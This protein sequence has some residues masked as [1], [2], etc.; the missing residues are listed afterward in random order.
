MDGH[1]FRGARIHRDMMLVSSVCRRALGCEWGRIGSG[2]SNLT[3]YANLAVTHLPGRWVVNSAP[4]AATSAQP[5]PTSAAP[6]PRARGSERRAATRQHPPPVAG[7]H[8][9]I[10]A[11]SAGRWRGRGGG[12]SSNCPTLSLFL[13]EGYY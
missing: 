10:P 9:T 7:A 5:S 11:R 6:L 12:T 4:S 8:T 2:A 13:V 1:Q 3:S